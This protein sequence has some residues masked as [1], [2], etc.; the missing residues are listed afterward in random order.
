MFKSIAHFGNKRS[1]DEAREK[2][3]NQVE[4]SFAVYTSLNEGRNPLAG[5]ET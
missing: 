4:E 2:F 5:L 1:I 3:R